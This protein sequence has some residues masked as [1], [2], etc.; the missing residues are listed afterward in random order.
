MIRASLNTADKMTRV[1]IAGLMLL[2]IILPYMVQLQDLP[3]PSCL[4]KSITGLSCPTCGISRAFY[5]TAQ[6][7]LLSA[8]EDNFVGIVVYIG[9]LFYL[10]K[11]LLELIRGQ[12]IKIRIPHNNH[13]FLLFFLIGGWISFWIVRLV[14]EMM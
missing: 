14:R 10:V 4:F 1:I 13:R 11:Y 3:L 8:M 2:L 9:L 6:G 7:S 5:S 12:R